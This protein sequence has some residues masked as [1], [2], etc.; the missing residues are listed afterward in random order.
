MNLWKKGL[1][2][3][4]ILCL[5]AG[6]TITSG[7]ASSDIP[8]D[9]GTFPDPAFLQWV[10]QSDTDAD[11]FL[12]QEERDAVTKMDL[13]KLGIRDL[14]G[15]EWFDALEKLNCSENE[16]VS[17]ELHD[18]PALTLLTCNEN[19]RLSNLT[20][21]DLPALEHLYCFHSNL[22]QLD[23][24]GVP[25]LT[26]L[27]WGASPL[28]ELDLSGNPNL[29]TLHVLGGDLTHA[30]LSHNEKLDTLLWN[31]TWIETLDLSHQ[32]DL[33]YLNCTDNQLTSLDLSSN[34]KLEAVYAG[35]N[36]LLAVRMPIGSTPFCD[37]TGQHAASFQLPEGENS[38]A[39]S[40]L[41]PWMNVGQV[42]A[43]SGGTL[44]GD[45]VR[46]DA[47]NQTVTYR[48]TDKTAVLDAS[49]SVI[50]ENSWQ[51]PL[52]IEDWTYGEPAA[53]PQAQPAFGTVAYSYGPSPQGPFQTEPPINAGKWYVRAV[54]AE[55]PH[56]QG[57]EAVAS[58]QIYPAVPEYLAPDVKS[59]IYGDRLADISLERGFLW[60]NGSL[61][62][63]D[64]GEQ[65][66]FAFYLPED[67]IDYQVVKHIPV[68][69]KVSPY[70]GTLLSIPPI[71]S[72]SEAE[73]L[74]LKHGDWTLKK[75]T[76]YVTELKEE[77]RSVQCTIRFQGNYMG[78]VIRTFSEDSQTGTGSE[79]GGGGS[80]KPAF[81]ISAQATSGGTITPNGTLWVKRGETP[82]FTMRAD[83]GFR[84]KA[85]LVDGE[86]VGSED[87][88]QFAP[89]SAN[90]TISAE[91][92][93]LND[94]T[95]PDETGVS[96][97]LDTQ[98]HNVYMRGYPGNRF[99]PDDALTRAQAAQIFYSLLR[100]QDIPIVSS[101][102]DVPSDAWYAKAVNTL[103]SLGTVSGVGGNRFLPERPITRAEFVAMAMGFA[104]PS[105]HSDASFTD[106]KPEDW[107]YQAVMS[108]ADYGWIVGYPDGTFGP[109]HL[110]TRGQAAAMV[111]RILDRRADRDFI[112]GHTG[113]QTFL[114]VPVSHWAY[115]DI[116]EAANAHHYTRPDWEERWENLC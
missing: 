25:N 58:F 10:Q 50:G 106:V 14:S 78:T 66:H 87:T 88:Y 44:D 24:H 73:N 68:L 53:S 75:G 104:E 19:A 105:Y 91:F 6:M 20:L 30:D 63:G 67:L 113:L 5:T 42:E 86:S 37:L 26:Y 90:H 97:Y 21:S 96:E 71:S 92:V 46:L 18:F 3:C 17:L 57:L 32:P 22:S 83:E 115:Y 77:G 13:R 28:K 62:V 4:L 111:N 61:W 40:E 59:A 29:N 82:H 101:F 69:V 49:L 102:S 70:D 33:T 23:L 110:V 74:V 76:D 109:D 34:G 38:F 85:V 89:V 84:L 55:T 107:Y 60:E 79:S 100:D 56:Y 95:S 2:L 48:Y 1:A 51:V 112:S 81:S 15:L 65:T 103:A 36:Q 41:V 35:N 52:S 98:A 11:G 72:R 12:S 45:R 116:C 7:A 94:P 80:T 8:I 31:H 39:F 108:A 43:L 114:D 16:L 9:S 93:P 64:A 27:A 47:P 99:G 54:V